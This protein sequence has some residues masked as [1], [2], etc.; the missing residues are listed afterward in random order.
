[1]NYIMAIGLGVIAGAVLF[2]WSLVMLWQ[3][4]DNPKIKEHLQILLYFVDEQCDEYEIPARRI[5]IIM[6]IQQLLGWKRLFLPTIV[7]GFVLDVLVKVIRKIGVPDLH[8]AEVN[9][10]GT[11]QP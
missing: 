8:Q 3:H 1:M 9:E 10:N 11:N 5:A 7:V 6:A 4:V 2:I